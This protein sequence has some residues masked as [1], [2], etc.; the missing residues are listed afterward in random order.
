MNRAAEVV[1]LRSLGLSLAQIAQVVSG[2]RHRLEHTLAEH[3]ASL[4]R[5]LRHAA[6]AVER[7]RELRDHMAGGHTPTLS[8]LQSVQATPSGPV[9]A[10]DLPW[11]WGGEPFELRNVRTLN[12]IVG[13]LFSGKTRLARR[14]AETL[15]NA[16]FF[17]LERLDAGGL[18]AD[19]QRDADP[20][21][22]ARVDQ[23]LAWLV[24]DGAT[25]SDALAFLIVALES[26]GSNALVVDMIE[27][28]LNA[29]TQEAL[30]AHLRRGGG[31]G[32]TLFML[33]R[34]S[35]IL[36]LT[37]VGPHESILYCPANHSVPFYVAACPGASGYESVANCLA[38]PEVRARTEGVVA[39][40]PSAA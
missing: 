15:P 9:V 25:V 8:D 20:A 23:A 36:D 11:P 21:L 27:H 35:A 22:R 18:T 16:V 39:I 17:G 12:Y 14:I 29:R 7:V 4:E 32:R 26:Q 30:I 1:A 13:P 2:H 34:S 37:A 28:G 31:F 10:F 5:Q 33:T 24:E 38:P 40:L 3:Q 19:A 6:A